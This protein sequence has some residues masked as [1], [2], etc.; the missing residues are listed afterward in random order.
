MALGGQTAVVSVRMYYYYRDRALEEEEWVTD[1][2]AETSEDEDRPEREILSG[3]VIFDKFSESVILCSEDSGPAGEPPKH[4]Y[5]D[6]NEIR[7]HP[8]TSESSNGGT[9]VAEAPS[10]RGDYIPADKMDERV[11]VHQDNGWYPQIQ[12]DIN[13]LMEKRR[14][15]SALAMELRLFCIER[16][17]NGV[18]SLFH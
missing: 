8:E 17:S 18:T 13:G 6:L 4:N 12:V 3:S 16:V 11:L 14:N 15:S 7:I 9:W 10:D 1:D 2:E 5:Y